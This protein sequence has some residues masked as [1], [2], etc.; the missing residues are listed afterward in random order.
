MITT[1]SATATSTP[2][3]TA[4]PETPTPSPSATPT[5]APLFITRQNLPLHV[6]EVGIG[7]AP[8]PLGAVGGTPPYTWSIGG[9]ALAPGLTLSSG[10]TVSGTPTANGS[11]G[12]TLLLTDSAGAAAGYATSVSILP[13][14]ALSGHCTQQCSVEAGCVTV[15]GVFSDISGGVQPYTFALTQGAI[16]AGMSLNGLALAGTF[17]AAPSPSAA[18][19]SYPFTVDVTD[20]LGATASVNSMFVVYP[21]VSLPSSGSCYGN[22]GTGC[23]AQLV[24]TGGVPGSKMTATFVSVAANPNPNP[25]N[26]NPGQCWSPP[27]PIPQ[28]PPQPSLPTVSGGSLVVN[29]PSGIGNG[30]GAIWTVL[31]DEQTPCAANT[32]CTSNQQTVVIGVQCS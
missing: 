12:F 22:F 15:C 27:S 20:A 5:P 29:I 16:P 11:F 7:F 21:H 9:G 18:P 28:M 23:Q 1:P 25:P 10:G 13:H 24:I 6:G 26:N 31:V 14:V 4:V 19:P 30:Y 8:A 3:P 32:D 2:T 17:P